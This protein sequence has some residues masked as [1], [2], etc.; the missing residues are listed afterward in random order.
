M[1]GHD[2][3]FSRDIP[4]DPAMAPLQL[5]AAV[6]LPLPPVAPLQ[7]PMIA[8]LPLTPVAS[9]PLSLVVL[10]AVP[11]PTVREDRG[12]P[13]NQRGTSKIL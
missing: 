3:P 1:P 9:L 5:Q 13:K 11:T 10:P 2:A 4:A 8:P 12:A 7:I 6:P